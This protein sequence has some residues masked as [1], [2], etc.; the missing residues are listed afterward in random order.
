M[1]K[2]TIILSTSLLLAGAL[3]GYLVAPQ[4]SMNVSSTERVDGKGEILFYRNTMNPSVTSPVP[5]KDNMGM[6]YKPVYADQGGANDV[7][8]TVRID[9]VVV[10]NIGVRTAKAVTGNLSRTIRA[11]GKV[12]YNEEKMARIHPKIEGWV[13]TLYVDKTGDTVEVDTILLGVYSPKLVSTQQEYLLSLSN[14]TTL[15]NSTFPDVRNG[16]KNLLR[17]TYERLQLLDVPDHQIRELEL[18][19]KVKKTLHIHTPVAG[20]V[21]RIGAREGQYITP[22]TELYMIADL[23]QVWVYVDIYEYEIPWVKQGDKVEMEL[24]G[25][26]GRVF[27]GKISYIYPY[28]EAKTRTIKARVVFDNPDLILRPEMFAEMQIHSEEQKNVV[29]VPAEA[30]IRSGTRN[31]VFVVREKGKFEP[32]D[33]ILGLESD[34]KVIVLSGVKPGDTVVT[35]AQ[36]L[37]DSESKLREA[38]QK[39]MEIKPDNNPDEATPPSGD[40]KGVNDDK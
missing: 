20:T 24:A 10:Q 19:K 9:P 40:I 30:V 11:V 29:I 2:S 17:T 37:I 22:N 12:D 13:E 6:D 14:L 16:A 27:T 33:V 28:A 5:A 31:Q 8:G 3:I 23:S 34:G 21:V 26:P 36:F 7:A 39:M 25:I 4:S 15:E 32:R 38:T 35:S 1:N 18:S